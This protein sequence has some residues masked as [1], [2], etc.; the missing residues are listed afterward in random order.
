MTG[1][2]RPLLTARQLETLRLVANGNTAADIARWLW[3][4][5]ETVNSSLRRTYRAL[6]VDDRA[7]AVAVAMRLGLLQD[8]D[9]TVPEALC[10]PVSLAPAVEAPEP[11][12]SPAG[13]SGD[14]GDASTGPP[15]PTRIS[16][17][18]RNSPEN[19]QKPA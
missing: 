7:H 1:P 19:G 15:S 13:R 6:G 4:S 18:D 9:V 8:E 16:R 3:V 5:P 17:L 11:H 2:A 14:D 12:P 10:G